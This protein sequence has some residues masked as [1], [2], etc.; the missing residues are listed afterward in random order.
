MMHSIFK[1]R[2]HL[3]NHCVHRRA[4]YLLQS[5]NSRNFSRIKRYGN[6]PKLINTRSFFLLPILCSVLYSVFKVSPKS[7]Q[8]LCLSQPILYAAVNRSPQFLLDQTL[9]QS[10]QANRNPLVLS[11][12]HVILC[13]VFNCQGEKNI[14]SS[15]E[16]IFTRSICCNQPIAAI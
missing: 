9:W 7:D 13:S 15:I 8:I 12:P 4:F 1:V 14:W 11:P 16:F 3:I 6:P 2:K 10:P 5:T